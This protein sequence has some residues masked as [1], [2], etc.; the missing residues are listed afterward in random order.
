MLDTSLRHYWHPVATSAE[1]KDQPL[2]ATLLDERI[3]LWRAGG[4]AAAFKDLCIHR[5]SALSL[6]SVQ[7]EKLVCGY[8]GWEYCAAGDCVRIPV[9][10]PEQP[11]PRKARAVA[12]YAVEERYGVV[13]LCLDDPWAPLPT[14]P[15]IEDPGYHTYYYGDE[16]WET[17]AARMIENFID[18]S[19]FPFV[20]AGINAS[21][22]NPRIPDF[23]VEERGDELYFEVE[24]EPLP[25]DAFAGPAALADYEAYTGGR[26]HYRVIA[27]FTAQA[28][29]PMPN[30][31]RQLISIVASPLSEKRMRRFAWSSRNF[32]FDKPDAVFREVM[33]QVIAQDR[34][35]VESQRPEELPLDLREELHLRGPD[36]GTLAYRRLLDGLG[37]SPATT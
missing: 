9:L 19:H 36:A 5:G 10:A 11:I 25:R 32:A 18:T 13:W 14:L 37:R 21:P 12:V 7:G 28:I 31:Q 33:Q 20:H 27:P 23:A 29:R 15:E 24:F 34:R 1:L 16:V 35:M 30:G 22:E 2:A 26:R 17:S 4:R 8:H 6:G 3:V